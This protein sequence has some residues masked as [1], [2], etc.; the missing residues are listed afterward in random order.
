MPM[1]TDI[2]ILATTTT[3]HEVLPEEGLVADDADEPRQ[4]ITISQAMS[5]IDELK[6]FMFSRPVQYFDPEV[7]QSEAKHVRA[8]NKLMDDLTLRQNQN[9]TQP[10]ITV[11]FSTKTQAK[12]S[13]HLPDVQLDSNVSTPQFTSK[14]PSTKSHSSTSESS[15]STSES[16][17]SESDNDSLLDVRS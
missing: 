11:F 10:K 5:A 17:S 9:L 12:I 3:G 7:N 14:S 6:Y 1:P 15:H 4:P 13:A 2:E 16:S 8:L